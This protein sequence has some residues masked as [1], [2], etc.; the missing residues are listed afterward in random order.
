MGSAK[1]S[2]SWSA[3]V[4]TTR[5]GESVHGLTILITTSAARNVRSLSK[6]SGD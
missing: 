2:T 4:D 3:E 1:R 5:H 6:S